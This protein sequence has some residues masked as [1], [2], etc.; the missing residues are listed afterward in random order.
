MRPA[1]LARR[2]PALRAAETRHLA[3]GLS[4]LAHSLLIF[5]V[6]VFY[7]LVKSAIPGLY[8]TDPFGRGDVY[9]GVQQYL[10]ILS[11]P[12]AWQSLRVT[13]LFALYTVAG[14]IG[15]GLA[16]ALLANAQLRG[17]AVYRT[18]FSSTVA[19]SV[20]VASLVWLLLF[21]PSVGVLNY[22]LHLLGRSPVG[23]LISAH[24]ALFSVSLATIWMQLG[25]NMLI[26]L[27]GL[28]GIPEEIYE[29]ARVDGSRPLHTFWRITLPLLSPSL[30]FLLLVSTI[31]SFESFGQI[32]ILTQ[33]GP[34]GSTNVLV[35]SI[36]RN[37]F[38]NFQNGPASIQALLLFVIIL[39]LTAV[40]F[41]VVERKVVY[42]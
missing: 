38:F 36:Y 4:F 35:Y 40:Q 27:A 30:F 12:A 2:T 26:L 34:L 32:H 33:G 8:I 6:F 23:W 41:L 28:Q 42:Q 19:C 17:I 31:H 22:L 29:S 37:A 18:I 24:W 13:A 15:L 10:D 5:A 14:G 9:V 21:N 1:T 16:L 25:F 39:V 3:L 20:A 7:P 11:S